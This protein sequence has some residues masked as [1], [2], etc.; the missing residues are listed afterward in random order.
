M[1]LEFTKR[2]KRNEPKKTGTNEK[3]VQRQCIAV[4][5]PFGRQR[6]NIDDDT[7]THPLPPHTKYF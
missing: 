4:E 5:W 1:Y 2:E 6:E 3:N 7:Q